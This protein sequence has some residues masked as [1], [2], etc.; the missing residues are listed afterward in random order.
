MQLI[1]YL[2][3][4]ERGNLK[5]LLDALEDNDTRGNMKDYIKPHPNAVLLEA[6]ILFVDMT[7]A[8]GKSMSGFAMEMLK[9]FESRRIQNVHR[10]GGSEPVYVPPKN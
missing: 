2:K 6:L 9:R 7:S 4:A 3:I 10:A 1:E 5:E 8:T